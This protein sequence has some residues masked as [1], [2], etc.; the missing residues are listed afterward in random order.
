MRALDAWQ[1]GY[2]TTRTNMTLTLTLTLTNNHRC[3]DEDS[4]IRWLAELAEGASGNQ[5]ANEYIIALAI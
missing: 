2:L 4:A 1:R 5:A 3:V